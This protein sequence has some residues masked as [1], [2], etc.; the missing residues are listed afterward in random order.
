MFSLQESNLVLGNV[1]NVGEFLPK[2]SENCHHLLFLANEELLSF[3]KYR[4]CCMTSSIDLIKL[5]NLYPNCLQDIACAYPGIFIK[6]GRRGGG[7]QAQLTKKSYVF[8]RF[9]SPQQGPN[10]Y[11]RENYNF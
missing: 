3:L 11:F 7:V 2:V 8:V 6:G 10:G 1:V 5:A 4:I 9:F